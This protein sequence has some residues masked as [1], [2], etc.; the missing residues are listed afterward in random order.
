MLSPVFTRVEN[1][2]RPPPVPSATI[3]DQLR[4]LGELRASGT[5]NEEEFQVLKAKLIKST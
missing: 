4:Q 5:I 3:V 2:H 1:A